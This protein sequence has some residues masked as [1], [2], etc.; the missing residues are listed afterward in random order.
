MAKKQAARKGRREYW[1]KI[2]A[3]F[4][5][6]G[7]S[8]AAFCKRER[9]NLGTFR[10]WLYRVRRDAARGKPIASFVE[11]SETPARSLGPCV[12]TAR[13]TKIEFETSPSVA[14]LAQLVI[15]L[16]HQR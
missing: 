10:T 5:R 3:R 8:H 12:V 2:V 4:E 14:D 13:G 7:L 11:V 9:L 16:D 1:T 6:S 15:A